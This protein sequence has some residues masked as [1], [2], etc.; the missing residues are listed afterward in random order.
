LTSGAAR[1]LERQRADRLSA[2]DVTQSPRRL[3]KIVENPGRPHGARSSSADT[4]RYKTV[5]S[6]SKL[7]R[8][9]RRALVDSSMAPAD[10]TAAL[11][12]PEAR[13]VDATPMPRTRPAPPLRVLEAA[14]A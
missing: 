11:R 13:P 12:L 7:R 6:V 3:L 8:T 9:I 5:V 4:C 2:N 1:R 14:S 10:P